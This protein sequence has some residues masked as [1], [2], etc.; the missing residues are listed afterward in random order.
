VRKLLA[1]TRECLLVLNS[2]DRRIF[3]FIVAIQCFLALLDLIGVVIIGIVGSLSIQGIQSKT[4]QG[5]T[6][7]ALEFLNIS[8]LPLQTQVT[9][10]TLLAVVALLLKT[11]LSMVFTKRILNFLS[12]RG[13]DTAANLVDKLL[14]EPLTSI[15]SR[16]SHDIEYAI[17]AGLSAITLGVL[18][19]VV[20][21]L[22]DLT[23]VFILLFGVF[24]IDPLI[25][26]ITI[27]FLGGG[28]VAFYTMMHNKARILGATTARM[29]IAI[30]GKI[31][32]V[33]SLYR[34]I[35]V[36]NKRS[37]YAD[38]IRKM[39]RSYSDALAE[40][41]FMPSIS[42]YVMEISLI[43]S[44]VIV[45]AIQFLSNDAVRATASLAVFLAATSRLAPALLRIQQSLVQIQIN[46]G[47][48]EPTLLILRR[49]EGLN[50][51]A[52]D[53]DFHDSNYFDFVPSIKIKNIS[54]I[55]PDSNLKV[56][57]NISLEIAEGTFVAVVGPSGSGKTTLIDILLGMHEPLSGTVQISGLPP[58][59]AIYNWPGAISYVPQ[60]VKLINGTIREN[61]TF[62][63]PK[64]S[65]SDQL[66]ENSIR[67]AS[68]DEFVSG[69]S[70]GVET[71]IGK[72]GI[73]M[74][75]G[76]AQ[77]IGIARALFTNPKL[78]ILDEATSSLDNETE[79]DVSKS[80]SQLKGK[81]TLVVIAHRLSTIRK[82][83]KVV[84]LDK[85]N[86]VIEGTFDEVRRAVPG[87]DVHSEVF[88]S[89]N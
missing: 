65:D 86:L 83:D 71:L 88:G 41:T 72:N 42:K 9:V 27:L 33:L 32:E 7:S 13:S 11:I 54:F 39:K 14:S 51:V 56:L 78:L 2:R 1:I 68:L 12:D 35:Y 16:D 80:I 48:A 44:I 84:Y 23:L 36:R 85:G 34:E 87:F 73:G 47:I 70:D 50:P 64:E 89:E 55:Y 53:N 77:R 63:Y 60:S 46:I 21:V 29:N 15:H 26:A 4:P 43:I 79:L 67:S 6:L 31:S 76:Q 19:L 52:K 28:G 66:L 62:G 3:W 20:T 82:A 30:N 81:V 22:S 5:K 57:N 49:A 74:S 37:Y 58:F 61:I 40:Q 10:L 69:L 17:G 18:G 25:A 24:T 38:E 59:Q 45:S 75:G 8:G